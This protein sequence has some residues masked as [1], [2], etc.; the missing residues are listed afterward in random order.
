MDDP[1]LQDDNINDSTNVI[2]DNSGI[3]SSDE[4]EDVLGEVTGIQVVTT[5]M[6][7]ADGDKVVTENGGELSLEVEEK[8]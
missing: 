7:Y 1:E 6:K 5:G 8:G 3:S 2:N 4:G